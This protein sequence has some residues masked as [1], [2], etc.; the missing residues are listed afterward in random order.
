MLEAGINQQVRALKENVLAQRCR[1]IANLLVSHIRLEIKTICAQRTGSIGK[2][3]CA[4]MQ[5]LAFAGVGGGFG[6]GETILLEQAGM[7]RIGLGRIVGVLRG[8]LLPSR[9]VFG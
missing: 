8:G 6:V 5:L 1:A 9:K 3:G 4:E 2:A 7:G